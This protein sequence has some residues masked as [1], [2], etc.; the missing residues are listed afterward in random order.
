MLS[1][2]TFICSFIFLP[3]T[4]RKFLIFTESFFYGPLSLI[5]SSIQSQMTIR[6]FLSLIVSS[7]INEVIRP[8]LNF[9]FFFNDKISQVQ[10]KH[11][12]VIS[13]FYQFWFSRFSVIYICIY[14]PKGDNKKI[15]FYLG[16]NTFIYLVKSSFPS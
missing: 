5:L 6:L 14:L 10:K 11:K 15:H 2:S 3:V 16:F 9:S 4:R 8:V 7:T 13:V 1:K 12:S